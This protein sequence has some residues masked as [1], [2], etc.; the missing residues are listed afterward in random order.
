MQVLHH[1]VGLLNPAL[2]F[3]AA[4]GGSHGR[5]AALRD[6]NAGNNWFWKA[7]PGFDQATGLGT[8]DVANMFDAL[9]RLEP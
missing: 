5:N 3:I 4:T 7:R 8:W 2:Y 9:R 6:I 1:R